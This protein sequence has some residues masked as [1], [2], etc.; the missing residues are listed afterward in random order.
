MLWVQKHCWDITNGPAGQFKHC[1]LI[2]LEPSKV[3]KKLFIFWQITYAPERQAIFIACL[4]RRKKISAIECDLLS[5]DSFATRNVVVNLVLCWNNIV[6]VNCIVTKHFWFEL[7]S[8]YILSTNKIAKHVN[9]LWPNMLTSHSM[10]T[11][12]VRILR[13]VQPNVAVK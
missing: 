4:K 9:H 3:R 6:F 12:A 5:Y 10:K 11:I 1:I 7:F 13:N 2:P 8:V